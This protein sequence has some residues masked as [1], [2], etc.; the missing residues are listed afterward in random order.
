MDDQKRAVCH[1]CGWRSGFVLDDTA[2]KLATVHVVLEHPEMYTEATGKEPPYV[3]NMDRTE[4]MFFTDYDA[5]RRNE[6]D[7][8]G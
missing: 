6:T 2:R 7:G 3:S 5:M 1:V 8:A 4:L